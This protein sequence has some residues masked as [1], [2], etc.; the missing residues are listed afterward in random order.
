MATCTET[1]QNAVQGC[2]D[3]YA[4]NIAPTVDRAVQAAKPAFDRVVACGSLAGRRIH[5][6]KE[7]T[8]DWIQA[9]FGVTAGAVARKVADV[10]PELG[11]MLALFSGF[12]IL[13]MG[14]LAGRALFCLSG[15]FQDLFKND[16]PAAREHALQAVQ[17]MSER[18]MQGAV[19]TSLV[20]GGFLGIAGLF[21]G[22]LPLIAR[23]GVFLCLGLAGRTHL[24]PERAEESRT[25]TPPPQET[26]E[27]RASEE[28]SLISTPI[29]RPPTPLPNPAEEGETLESRASGDPAGEVPHPLPTKVAP[30]SVD[31]H[32]TESAA[33][34]A[35]AQSTEAPSTVL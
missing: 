33:G 18:F 30:L 23:G 11:S 16:I 19:L 28:A 35:D 10:L 21:T 32:H 26:L 17:K 4:H 12:T 31:E 24:L 6:I 20:T 14:V 25:L 22:S 9:R 5:Q 27:R 34:L 3:F 13:P 15:T 2:R 7:E 1:F 29:S 8:C